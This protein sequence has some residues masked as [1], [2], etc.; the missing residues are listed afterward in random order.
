MIHFGFG[1]FDR[2]FY[3]YLIS[4]FLALGLGSEASTRLVNGFLLDMYYCVNAN[5]NLLSV[6]HKT[7][8]ALYGKQGT[9]HKLESVLFVLCKVTS[10]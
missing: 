4:F 9:R 3:T 1:A 6:A 8:N 2:Y 7:R 10:P 5:V